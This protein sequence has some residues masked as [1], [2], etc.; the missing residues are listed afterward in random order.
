MGGWGL[1]LLNFESTSGH[2]FEKSFA[3]LSVQGSCSRVDLGGSETITVDFWGGS[4]PN[5]WHS[6]IRN[7]VGRVVGGN[8]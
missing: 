5:K 8:L 6:G 7:V 1:R 3:I 2:N 4:F